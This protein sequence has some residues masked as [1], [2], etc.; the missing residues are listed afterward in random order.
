[1]PI[2]INGFMEEINTNVF[3]CVSTHPVNAA[4]I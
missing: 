3:A 1:M 2:E 4:N